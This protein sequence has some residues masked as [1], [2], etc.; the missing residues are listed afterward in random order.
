[1][2]DAEEI[3]FNELPNYQ[4]YGPMTAEEFAQVKVKGKGLKVFQRSPGK[5]H[6]VYYI[7][8]NRSEEEE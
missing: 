4:I 6:Y 1:M 8:Q 2:R 7:D 3:T 5:P